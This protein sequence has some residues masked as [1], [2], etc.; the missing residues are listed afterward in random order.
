MWHIE[1]IS[2]RTG[3]QGAIWG[4]SGNAVGP[5]PLGDRLGPQGA[6]YIVSAGDLG[7]L[8][9]E[10]TGAGPNSRTWSLLV[11][12]KHQY[13]YRDEG[14]LKISID[15]ANVATIAGGTAP[16]S[17]PLLREMDEIGPLTQ[18]IMK[19]VSTAPSL[20]PAW[21]SDPMTLMFTAGF[22]KSSMI[23]LREGIGGAPDCC[24]QFMAW[25]KSV[26]FTAGWETD[27]EASNWLG[28]ALCKGLIVGAA[29][30]AFVVVAAACI[31]AGPVSTP[32]IIALLETSSSI[33][34]LASAGGMTVEG[35]ANMAVGVFFAAGATAFVMSIIDSICAD[36]GA[37]SK[38]SEQALLVTGIGSNM[39]ATGR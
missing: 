32:A 11:N 36:T 33:A 15:A 6:A 34:A 9:I 35:V 1:T 16:L 25:L 3:E 27:A 13:L 8:T 28:C 31:A 14:M 21:N 22:P 7:S 37:C 39:D 30:A 10:D 5:R 12:G 24:T 19:L 20:Y 17:V 26:Q 23:N 4:G 38:S 29:A 18:Q 2:T